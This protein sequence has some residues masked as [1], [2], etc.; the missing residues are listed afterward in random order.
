MPVLTELVTSDGGLS[1]LAPRPTAAA[2]A[3]RQ[4]LSALNRRFQADTPGGGSHTPSVGL[5]SAGVLVHQLDYTAQR[6][7]LPWDPC[8]ATDRCARTADR[9]STTLLNAAA[10]HV[11]R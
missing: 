1:Q 4:W 10:P 11:F 6:H 3:S 8:G 5:H 9:F 2:A 7:G